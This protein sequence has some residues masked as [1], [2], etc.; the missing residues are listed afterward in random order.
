MD[1]NMRRCTWLSVLHSWVSWAFGICVPIFTQVQMTE[2]KARERKRGIMLH[3]ILCSAWCF[4]NL[5]LLFGWKSTHCCLHTTLFLCFVMYL[6]MWVPLLSNYCKC[7]L[8]VCT[9]NI[10]LKWCL[11]LVWSLWIFYFS[12]SFSSVKHVVQLQRSHLTLARLFFLC[13]RIGYLCWRTSRGKT[14]CGA[15]CPL[16]IVPLWENCTVPSPYT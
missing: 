13:S 10:K 1:A 3:T 12:E 6:F 16:Q 7:F 8:S 5:W 15:L 9:L 4:F 2:P 11:K 14:P